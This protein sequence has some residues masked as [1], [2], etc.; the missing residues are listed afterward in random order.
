MGP[1]LSSTARTIRRRSSWTRALAVSNSERSTI[2]TNLRYDTPAPAGEATTSHPAA[3]VQGA[4]AARRS[5][6]MRDAA[7]RRQRPTRNTPTLPS[8]SK[9]SP[10]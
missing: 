10:A 5:E 7:N 3:R 6:W 1:P 9:R 4:G 8:R 2:G